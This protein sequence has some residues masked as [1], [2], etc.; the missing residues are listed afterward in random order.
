MQIVGYEN[1]SKD[2]YNLTR[3]LDQEL[4]LI[5]L[6]DP[7][8]T[9]QVDSIYSSDMPTQVDVAH[10]QL[11]HDF[12]VTPLRDWLNL[13]QQSTM[14]GRAQLRLA[15][16]CAMWSQQPSTEYLPGVIESANVFALTK[17]SQWSEQESRMMQQAGWAHGIRIV[18]ATCL[19]VVASW[20]LGSLYSEQQAKNLVA[21]LMEAE[22]GDVPQIIATIKQSPRATYLVQSVSGNLSEEADPKK[23]LH[24]QLARYVCDGAERDKVLEAL[25]VADPLE[26]QSIV[27]LLARDKN[28][29]AEQFWSRVKDTNE[30][31]AVRIR[32]ASAVANWFPEDPQWNEVSDLVLSLIH[33]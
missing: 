23:R 27:Q 18:A 26:T 20:F 5:T 29:F 17:P 1:R 6:T 28:T 30:T 21:R 8:G 9:L 13:K 22:T 12:L 32:L 25:L 2:F 14:R 4:L 15:K 33:I 3:I 24:L 10:F 11:T 31:P 16:R 19:L 7:L